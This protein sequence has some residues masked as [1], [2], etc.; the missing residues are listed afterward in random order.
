MSLRL[1][2]LFAFAVLPAAHAAPITFSFAGVVDND[3]FGVYNDPSNG[4]ATVSGTYFF[5]AT[6]PMVLSTPNS[7]GYADVR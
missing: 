6:I 2:A 7:G 3:P 1:L 4:P 5:N